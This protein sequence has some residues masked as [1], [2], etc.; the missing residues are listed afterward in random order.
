[1]STDGKLIAWFS[2]VG[3]GDIALAGGKGANLGEMSRAGMPVPPGFIV[4]A[5][6]Y[7]E[8]MRGA[9]LIRMARD[10]L[11]GLDSSDGKQL[12]QVA[13]EIQGNISQ[14]EM[15]ASLSEEIRR[16]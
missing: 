10:L 14:C 5:E 8:F 16:Y 6:A 13:S 1:M 3:Q 7:F 15:P 12:R 2:E 4:T 11:E 9:G